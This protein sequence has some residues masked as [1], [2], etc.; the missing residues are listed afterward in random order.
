MAQ[1][2][3]IMVYPKAQNGCL[4]LFPCKVSKSTYIVNYIEKAPSTTHEE[5]L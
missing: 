4:K 2:L 5:Q 1:E 3:G